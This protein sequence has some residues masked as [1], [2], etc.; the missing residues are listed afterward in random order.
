VRFSLAH[1]IAHTLFPDCGKIVRNRAARHEFS[2]DEWQLEMLCNIAASELLMPDSTFA[3][4]AEKRPLIDELMGLRVTFDVSTEALLLRYART[5]RHACFVFAA[6][7]VEDTEQSGP[8][9]I[10]YAVPAASWQPGVTSGSDLTDSTLV[11]Q[12]TA[13]DYTAKGDERWPGCSEP[14]HIEAIGVPPYPTGS[15]PRVVGVGSPLSDQPDER[16]LLTFVTGDATE[17]RGSGNR[18]IVHIVND[19]A[20]RWGGAFAGSVGA[21]WPHVAAD[22]T[23]WAQVDSRHLALGSCHVARATTDITVVSMVAQHGYGPSTKPRV[24]YAALETCLTTVAALAQQSNPPCTV[25]MPKIGTGQA[26]GRWA[27]VEEIVRDTL[28]QA[29]VPVMVYD[30][31]KKGKPET[32]ERGLFD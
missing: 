24:R 11:R 30:L 7:R 25:N 8:Y 21:K 32:K 22:F 6:S 3:T 2:G 29:D 17:P 4:L 28:V 12:C 14:F 23:D 10:D 13:V 31:P 26:G 20:V 15:L 1:E 18:I 16:D 9:R 5:T 19:A 27:L